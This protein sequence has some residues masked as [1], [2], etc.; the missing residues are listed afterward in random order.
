M[1]ATTWST[2]FPADKLNVIDYAFAFATPSGC[3]LSD[4]WSDFQ[5]PTWGPEGSVDGVADD[6][7]N[8]TSICSATS[9]SSSSSRPRIRISGRDV[10]R[11]LD[12]LDVLLRR[13]GNAGVA[14]CLRQLVHRPDHQGQP[15]HRRLARPGR[16][17]RRRGRPLRRH[18]HR[19]GVPGSRSRQRRASLARRRPQRDVAPAGVPAPTRRAGGRCRKALHAH[20]CDSRRQ[21]PLDGKL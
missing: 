12:G 3:A 15:A 21:H 1:R 17:H 8:P 5:A 4:V 14:R 10:D 11:R 2:R 19:L 18:Q 9:T 16:R 20:R 6:P 7:S 13:R